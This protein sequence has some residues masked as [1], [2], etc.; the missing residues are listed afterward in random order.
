MFCKNS[1]I[2][3]A[4]ATKESG[5]MLKR[6]VGL[7]VIAALAV[8]LSGCDSMGGSRT[9]QGAV[10]GGLGGA[11]LGAALGPGKALQ[12]AA[13]GGVAGVV[14]G[15]LIGNQMDKNESKAY[16]QGYQDRSGTPPPKTY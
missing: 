3:Y 13:I 14:G 4:K 6:M 1:V 12:N 10:M 7:S 11:A 8:A 9:Q 5:S 16:Q 2:Q 15:S